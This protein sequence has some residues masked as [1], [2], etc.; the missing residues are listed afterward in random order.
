[1]SYLAAMLLLVM[2]KFKAFVCLVALVG[3]WMLLPFFRG[4][5]T[6]ITRR[7]QLFK[8]IFHHN[9]PE[10]CEQFESEGILPQHYFIEWVMTLFAKSLNLQVASRVWDL[11]MLDGDII[12]FQVAVALLK[13]ISKEVQQC[14]MDIILQSLRSIVRNINDEDLIVRETYNVK[15]PEWVRTEVSSLTQ[16]F[17]PK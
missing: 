3:N 10:L 17:V 15:L 6:Q 12:L 13:L 11:Y 5:E 1:M 16:E 2:D 8:Q 7:L 4:D 14:S 9:L